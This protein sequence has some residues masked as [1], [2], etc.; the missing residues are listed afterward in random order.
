MRSYAV[1]K[2]MK[3]MKTVDLSKC[4]NVFNYYTRA[5]ALAFASA[6][7]KLRRDSLKHKEW[8]KEELRRLENEEHS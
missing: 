5:V 7:G 4:R 1:Y 3:S 6:A 2:L 8:E